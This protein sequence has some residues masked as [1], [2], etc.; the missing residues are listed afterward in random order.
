MNIKVVRRT[1][2]F[3]GQLAD[4]VLDRLG[5]AGM[6]R[7]GHENIVFVILDPQ[8]EFQGSLGPVLGHH[9]DLQ[10]GQISGSFKSQSIKIALIPQ[11]LRFQ[12][13]QIP[14]HELSSVM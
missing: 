13:P 2:L 3:G 11:V 7:P 14:R 5:F 9:L 6:A 12:L 1:G 10:G 8:A 4:I